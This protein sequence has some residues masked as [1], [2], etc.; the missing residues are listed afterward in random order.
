MER[1]TKEEWNSYFT[2]YRREALRLEMRDIY[3]TETEREKLAKWRREE[4]IDPAELHEWLRSWRETQRANMAAGKTMRR[5]RVVSEPVTDYIRFEYSM[6]HPL[7]EYGEDIRWLPREQASSLLLPGNDFWLFDDL[8]TFSLYSGD[9]R[10]IGYQA[11]DNP[12]VVRRCRESFEEAFK[13]AIPHR[14][15]RPA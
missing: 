6:S 2:S 15:Y 3:T 5:V 14:D 11:T 10:P 9:G 4:K 12:E 7:V 1:I 8:V 13:I